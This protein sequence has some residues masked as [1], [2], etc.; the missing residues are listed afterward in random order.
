MT[1]AEIYDA[2]SLERV[3]QR[4]M[5][6]RKHSWGEGDCSSLDVA[7]TV[8]A[9]VLGEKCGEVARAVLGQDDEAL[10]CE[11]VQV[12]AVAVAWLEAL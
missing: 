12:G 8:K 5:W 3:H 9:I 10:I 6:D 7:D 1:R 4:A 2:I 11:L